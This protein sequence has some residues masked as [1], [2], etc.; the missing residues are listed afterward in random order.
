MHA[1]EMT[2]EKGGLN[3]GTQRVR[4]ISNLAIA[5]TGFVLCSYRLFT[6][7]FLT[8]TALNE[9]KMKLCGIMRLMQDQ[10]GFCLLARSLPAPPNSELGSPLG[11]G[12]PELLHSHSA[13]I[14][15][16]NPR[17][18]WRCKSHSLPA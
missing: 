9:E 18:V 11:Q 3:N 1:T 12:K 17:E 15:L 13:A 16:C 7:I 8:L 2:N 6:E 4:Y 5:N 10:E 14:N